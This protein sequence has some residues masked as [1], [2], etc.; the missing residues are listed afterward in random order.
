MAAFFAADQ[1][2][3]IEWII[4]YLAGNRE[5]PLD[6][7]SAHEISLLM[8]P[9]YQL[10]LLSWL[11]DRPYTLLIAIAAA[12]G[13][14]ANLISEDQQDIATWCLKYLDGNWEKPLPA[15][16]IHELSKL[17][18]SFGVSQTNFAEAMRDAPFSTLLKAILVM[19]VS[20]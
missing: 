18:Y 19:N 2:A 11:K 20:P 3:R 17:A 4:K 13:S 6:E 7:K 8:G 16:V 14:H 9:G 5:V 15:E 1:V 12:V 10:E